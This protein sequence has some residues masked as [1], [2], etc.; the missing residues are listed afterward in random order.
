MTPPHWHR[1]LSID[2]G[3]VDS[4][5]FSILAFHRYDPTLYV[6]RSFKRA[7]TDV[8]TSCLTAKRLYDRA[9]PIKVVVDTGGL[10]R[11]IAEELTSRHHIPFHAAQKTDKDANDRLLAADLRTG[12]VK[13]VEPQCAD[14][15][16]E[17]QTLERDLKTGKERQG[18]ENHC[19]DTVR[20]GVRAARHYITEH[21]HPAPVPGS[22]EY[23]TELMRLDRERDLAEARERYDAQQSGR[24]E[25]VYRSLQ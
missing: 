1:I 22:V 9:K 25:D 4:D 11:K 24:L 10:G 20:Y 2:L 14:L 7:G 8:T 5:A 13:V 6:E 18:Q 19:V 15:V 21:W 23:E 3:F 16:K 17:L 12:R